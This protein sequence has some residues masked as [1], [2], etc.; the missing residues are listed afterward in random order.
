[1]IGAGNHLVYKRWHKRSPQE[2]LAWHRQVH[3]DVLRALKEAPEKW[4]DGRERPD[5][6]PF[7]MVGH[8]AVHRVKDIEQALNRPH[9]SSRPVRSKGE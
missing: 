8:L 4:F 5:Y 3:E 7:D 6:W 1:M 9:R 2:V